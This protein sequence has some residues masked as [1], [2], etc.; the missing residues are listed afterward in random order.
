MRRK[1]RPRSGRTAVVS[2]PQE[3]R[4]PRSKGR[5]QNHASPCRSGTAWKK[6]KPGAIRRN[7]RKPAKSATSTRNSVPS[8]LRGCRKNSLRVRPAI[9]R[10][11]RGEATDHYAENTVGGE[12]EHA[13][14]TIAS[15]RLHFVLSGCMMTSVA[16]IKGVW[17]PCDEDEHHAGDE[18]EGW[19]WKDH[20]GDQSGEPLR[21]RQHCNHPHGLR[22]A[23]VEPALAALARTR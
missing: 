11:C 2:L 22:P 21:R 20:R 6:F 9:D 8:P 15:A 5:R 23:G 13:N 3:V 16:T 18:S 17:I 10:H 1:L 14:G 4:S 19:C 7:T 12:T